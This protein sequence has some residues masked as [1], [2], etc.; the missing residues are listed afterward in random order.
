[1]SVAHMDPREFCW[2]PA[3]G[4]AA[5]EPEST[6]HPPADFSACTQK[7]QAHPSS[8]TTVRSE[9]L[10]QGCGMVFGWWSFCLWLGV[11]GRSCSQPSGFHSRAV[12]H[13]GHRCLR[14]A[15]CQS[16]VAWA[17]DII[18]VGPDTSSLI[19]HWAP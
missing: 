14:M 17:P 9:N 12:W 11:E 16:N 19:V 2:L 15:A 6:H 4:K 18:Y 5:I 7:V 13:A 10:E 8:G 3:R 1:M